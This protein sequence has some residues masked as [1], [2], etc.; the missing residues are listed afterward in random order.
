MHQQIEAF[1]AH[2]QLAQYRENMAVGFFETVIAQSNQ[3]LAKNDTKPPA[4]VALYA[5]GEVYAHRDYPGHDYELSRYYFE[6]LIN[7]FPQSELSSEAKIYLGLFETIDAK[8]KETA[9]VEEKLSEK[10]KSSADSGTAPKQKIVV[11]PKK[12]SALASEPQK[13]V[14]NQNFEEAV[15]KNKQILEELGNTKPADEALY[16]L[17]LI[18]A[19]VD[20][21]AKDYNKSKSYFHTL[22]TQF[23]DS[24]FAEEARIW[25]GLFETIEKIQQIDKEIEQQKKQLNQ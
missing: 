18:Y 11:E 21:P 5:L 24:E 23:P 7:N 19:H 15:K 6:K 14:E 4:D 12:I 25:L 20:N 2:Q 13:V 10:E 9:A 16:N 8:E 17:G 1:R 3:M 22:T